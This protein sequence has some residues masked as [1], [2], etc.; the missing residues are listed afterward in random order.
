MAP[1]TTV[2]D[3]LTGP[4]AIDSIT[5][6]AKSETSLDAAE[7]EVTQ[8][9]EERHKIKDTSE[10][11]FSVLNQGSLLETSSSTSSVFTTLLGEVAAI[12]LLVGGIGVMNIMLVSVTERT[13]EIGIRKAIG[14]QAQRHP[15]PVPDRGGARLAVRRAPGGGRRDHRQ[16]VRNRRRAPRSRRPTRYRSPSARRWRRACSSAPTP[17]PAPHRCGRSRRCA[18]SDPIFP[19]EEHAMPEQ[20]V[21]PCR[22]GAQAAPAIA[23]QAARA[24]ARLRE[25][26]VARRARRG[27]PSPPTPAPALPAAARTARRAA[28]GVRLHRRRPGR[29]G[30][31]LQLELERRVGPGLPLRGAARSGRP[32]RRAGSAAA[33]A[34]RSGARPA[35]FTRP[36]AGTVAYLDGSTL[37]VTN[38]EGNT[39]KV[40]TSDATTVSKT[41]KSSV[42]DIRPGET[43]TVRGRHRLRRVDHRRIAD[44]GSQRLRPGRIVRRTHRPARAPAGSSAA[45]RLRGDR[46]LFGGG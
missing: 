45:T 25:R 31:E 13:R 7:S 19:Q 14:A 29:E 37:Y 39:V 41:V 42:K 16:P 27:A 11:G 26:R 30:P 34:R 46:S 6:Q 3:A 1:I 24:R 9:L 10:P 20:P 18:L 43:V 40:I 12:S 17:R 4:G 5:V 23:P 35:G 8:I 32:A 15:H 22:P 28:H 33:R 2:Q 21:S 44:G 36:T 38:S